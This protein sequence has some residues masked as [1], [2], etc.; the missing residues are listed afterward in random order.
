M[1]WMMSPKRAGEMEL[2]RDEVTLMRLR[3]YISVVIAY[4]IHG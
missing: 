2:S 1:G 4:R 3:L